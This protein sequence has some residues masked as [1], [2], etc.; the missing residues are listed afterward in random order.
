MQEFINNTSAIA[1]KHFQK[2]NILSSQEIN[3]T[4]LKIGA[5]YDVY[6]ELQLDNGKYI[7]IIFY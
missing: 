4:T 6:G 2:V 3:N 7:Q 1:N 5:L